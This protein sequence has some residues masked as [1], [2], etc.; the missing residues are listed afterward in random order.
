MYS[1]IIIIL[2][3]IIF[4]IIMIIVVGDVV[5]T[6]IVVIITS[7]LTQEKIPCSLV[8]KLKVFDF[9]VFTGHTRR[10]ITRVERFFKNVPG[11][12]SMRHIQVKTI[13]I[14]VSKV[15]PQV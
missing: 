11:T 7:I 2:A 1:I 15:N 3:A 8:L 14:A 10:C 4:I 6:F 5:I 12:F 13:A 9:R